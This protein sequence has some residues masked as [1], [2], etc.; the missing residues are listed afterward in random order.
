VSASIPASW[1]ASWIDDGE[2]A[3]RE[4]VVLF[5][6][7]V[8][9]VEDP[10]AWSELQISADS[11][12]RLWLNGV[13]IARGPERW[14]VHH[15]AF[16]THDLS[17][18]VLPGTLNVLAVEVLRWGEA[19]PTYDISERP[20]LVIEGRELRTDASFRVR[21]F[22]GFN[23]EGAPEFPRIVHVAGNWLE[24]R[25]A[26]EEDA[27]W[28]QLDYDDSEW[29][30]ARE[31]ISAGDPDAPWTL[32]PRSIPAPDIREPEL[33]TVVQSGF[34]VGA[35][36]EPPFGY[37]IHR[38][39][40]TQS[41]PVEWEG[42]DDVHYLVF[43]AGRI[44][45]AYLELELRAASGAAVELMYAESPRLNFAKG[46]RDELGEQ[47]VEGYTDVYIAREGW[48]VYEPETRRTFRFIRVAVRSSASV[49]IRAL[50]MRRTSFPLE[51][52]GS[53]ECSDNTLNRIWQVG[54]E[55]C[56]LCAHDTYED[57]PHY[58]QLQ[59]TGDARIQSLICYFVGGEWR[60]AAKALRQ[61]A[62]E[63]APGAFL[64]S[65]YPSREPQVIPGFSLLWIEMLE[66]FQLY[67]GEDEIALELLPVVEELLATFAAHEDASGCLRELPMWN[68][69]DWAYPRKGVPHLA[70]DICAPITMLYVGA[71]SAAAR[72]FRRLGRE[73]AAALYEARAA[74]TGRTVTAQT[75][76]ERDSLFRDGV[77]RRSFSKHTNALALLYGLVTGERANRIADK[78]FTDERLLP[79][80]FYFDF[81]VHRALARI[82]RTDLL[83]ADL[84]RWRQMLDLGATAW[85]ELIDG[86]RSDCHVWS[87][88]PTY[89]LMSSIL[90]VRVLAAG[91]REVRVE[92]HTAGLEWFRGKVATPMGPVG[93]SWLRGQE[94]EVSLPEGVRGSIRHEDGRIEDC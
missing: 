12:Y 36:A 86:E 82:G 89:S 57:T 25:D 94:L 68:F 35:G 55:T 20:A 44:V 19:G 74:R 11:M 29:S 21:R 60:L 28:R 53:F 38:L 34:V 76:S 10:G 3:G 52:R 31:L 81:Y 42:G 4:D 50:R 71:L 43:D 6:R 27:E 16:D 93:V 85:F 63:H 40:G 56:Q 65:R 24:H 51:Q 72:L 9:R 61:L 80:S 73:S 47:R 15:R 91:C 59:Y 84:S 14:S 39:G 5:F 58:E 88:S 1:S 87:A 54:W 26:R 32:Y 49:T 45:T 64:H 67:S 90:G 62:E 78:L 41:L 7:R 70:G 18:L 75:Y 2:E 37:A 46:R 69:L 77:V 30:A 13:A 8:F 83:L 17:A 48:Q 92:P 33:P 79:T 22:T 23:R 66:E